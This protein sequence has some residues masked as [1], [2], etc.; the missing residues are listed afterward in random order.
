MLDLFKRLAETPGGSGF[1]E[2]VIEL[3][4]PELRKHPSEVTVGWD[5]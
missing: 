4:S 3:L 1:E 5:R 2:K